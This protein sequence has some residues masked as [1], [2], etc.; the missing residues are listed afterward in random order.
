VS[1]Q[2]LS[3][4][5]IYADTLRSFERDF[6]YA[7]SLAASLGSNSSPTQLW[8]LLASLRAVANTHEVLTNIERTQPQDVAPVCPFSPKGLEYFR[9]RLKVSDERWADAAGC[10]AA[11]DRLVGENV[12]TY[13][14]RTMLLPCAECPA[15]HPLVPLTSNRNA[16]PTPG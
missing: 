5:R 9:V 6:D 3:L 16:P 10:F 2:E 1:P 7:L 15:R 14:Q 13:L 8:R 4:A 12:F 11:L